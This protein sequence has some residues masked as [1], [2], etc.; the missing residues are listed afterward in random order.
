MPPI[1]EEYSDELRCFLMLCFQHDLADRLS[2]EDLC[3]HEWLKKHWG[4]W[5]A[6]LSGKY[7]VHVQNKHWT[8]QCAS[9][10]PASS[11]YCIVLTRRQVHVSRCLPGYSRNRILPCKAMAL[12]LKSVRWRGLEGSDEVALL[13]TTPVAIVLGNLC[14]A[15]MSSPIVPQQSPSLSDISTPSQMVQLMSQLWHSPDRSK[16]CRSP[17]S[18]T[19]TTAP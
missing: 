3:D 12:A 6:F 2:A 10:S 4:M 11:R 1:P 16:F 13:Q 14:L 15:V 9:I 18:R 8:C 5:G 17:F 19:I 7:S